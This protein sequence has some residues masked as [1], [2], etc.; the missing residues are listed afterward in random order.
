MSND[1][2]LIKISSFFIKKMKLSSDD[3]GMGAKQIYFDVKKEESDFNETYIVG[4]A[5]G[6]F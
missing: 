2:C 1:A 3:F 5:S 4:H 6:H